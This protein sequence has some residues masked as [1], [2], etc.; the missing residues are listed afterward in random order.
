MLAIY[1]TQYS[2]LPDSTSECSICAAGRAGHLETRSTSDAPP[3]YNVGSSG[4]RAMDWMTKS[5]G[6]SYMMRMR[7][8]AAA[9]L[10]HSRATRRGRVPCARAGA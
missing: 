7:N 8:E 9:P 1:R 10:I 3:Q 2:L 4:S 6:V 5:C